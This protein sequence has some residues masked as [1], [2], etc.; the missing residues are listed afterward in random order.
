MGSLLRVRF[1]QYIFSS[2]RISALI[3]ALTFIGFIFIFTGIFHDS[4]K[5][6]LSSTS[7][8]FKTD[9]STFFS[10]PGSEKSPIANLLQRPLGIFGDGNV[11]TSKDAPKKGLDPKKDFPENSLVFHNEKDLHRFSS[12]DAWRPNDLYSKP[13][14]Q[15]TS[16]L[17]PLVPPLEYYE[18][19]RDYL[20]Q[21]IVAD[22][23]EGAENLFLMMKEGS[24]VLFE[25]VPIH[26]TTTFTKVPYFS[27]YADAPASIGGYEVIDILANV[28]DKTKNDWQFALYTDLKK[29]RKYHAIVDPAALD[30]KGGW[31]LDKFK[32]VP[33]LAHAFRTAS[34]STKWFAFMDGDTYIFWDNLMDYLNKLDHTK[35]LYLGSSSMLNG[36][37]F[38]HGG[39]GVVISRA[40]LEQTLGK[41]PEWEHT[42]EE[43]AL[44]VCCGDYMVAKLLS[45]ADIPLATG[46][47]Y[48][49]VGWKFQGQPVWNLN[50]NP[51]TWCQKVVSF[52]HM[53]PL[54]VE[55]LWEFER[56]LGPEKKKHITYF[57]IYNNFVAPYISKDMEYWNS[58]A[59][60]QVYSE[61]KDLEQA[62]REKE[63]KERKE[64]EEK[65]KKEKEEKEKK[66][67]EEKE[68]KAEEEK[69]KAEEEKKKE[70]AERKKAEAEKADS[71]KSS[72]TNEEKTAEDKKKEE[73]EALKKAQQEEADKNKDSR[74]KRDKNADEK[75]E[76]KSR[77]WHSRELCEKA[78]VEWEDCLSW[79]F[80]PKQKYCGLGR[81]IK[82]GRPI[83]DFKISYHE[84]DKDLNHEDAH[85]GYMIDRIRKMRTTQKC[86]TLYKKDPKEVI[87]NWAKSDP[88]DRSEGWFVRF[89]QD[90]AAQ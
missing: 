73:A 55:L 81:A 47:K 20:K 86:D 2:R 28:T 69:K 9:P 4:T 88:A 32:N 58:M 22:Y 44:R 64:K 66:E 14:Y 35:P 78:C 83:L 11:Y 75:S 68:K 16:V 18:S 70:E 46:Y 3:F 62:L 13:K 12:G 6:Y 74:D 85:S 63:E 43:E 33:M 49:E 53:S 65:E 80:L 34:N 90:E 26:F 7:P 79:R 29:L 48:P 15:D 59:S 61:K 71:D 23:A 82:L 54:D 60:D 37:P 51:E 41:H 39:S 24:N 57:D 31:E 50:A 45:L 67:K 76:E 27:I 42:L 21:P 56:L 38:G 52:H 17:R 40:A 84:G 89:Q 5:S 77:P 25:R 19:K 1:I 8:F 10:G 72:S 30:L 87:N 36:I